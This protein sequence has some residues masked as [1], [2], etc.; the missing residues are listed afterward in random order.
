MPDGNYIYTS[1]AGEA[2]T[3]AAS[4]SATYTV[5]GNSL[6]VTPPILP[7]VTVTPEPSSVLLLATGLIGIVGVMQRKKT[8]ART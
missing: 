6:P 8:G 4:A 2:F 1:S 3:K 5:T 7:P